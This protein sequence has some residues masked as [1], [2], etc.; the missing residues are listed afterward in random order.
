MT[1]TADHS[2]KPKP[3]EPNVTETSGISSSQ[4]YQQTIRWTPPDLS[5]AVG[6]MEFDSAALRIGFNVSWP[7]MVLLRDRA[8]LGD[9]QKVPRVR[10]LAGACPTNLGTQNRTTLGQSRCSTDPVHTP[11]QRKRHRRNHHPR[12]THN[13]VTLDVRLSSQRRKA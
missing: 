9:S 7:S 1:E 8:G 4:S 5:A 13:R 11:L 2:D 3:D 6:K 10:W 12:S